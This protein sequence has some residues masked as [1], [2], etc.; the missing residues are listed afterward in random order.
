VYEGEWSNDK[1]HGFGIFMSNEG[2]VYEG[3]WVNNK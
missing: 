3:E 1:R 2:G